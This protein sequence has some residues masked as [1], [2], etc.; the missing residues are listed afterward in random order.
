MF[1]LFLGSILAIIFGI[2]EKRNIVDMIAFAIFA[3]ISFFI[4][5]ALLFKKNFF[6][7]IFKIILQ[8]CKHY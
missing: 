1:V 4:L 3:M 7:K 6:K 5:D 8:K 2:A